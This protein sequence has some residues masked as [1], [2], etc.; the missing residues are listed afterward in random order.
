MGKSV[1]RSCLD[2]AIEQSGEALL[3]GILFE[4]DPAVIRMWLKELRLWRERFDGSG[5]IFMKG[6][7]M[8][9]G[10]VKWFSDK[11][12]YG[13]IK[14]EEDSDLFVHHTGIDAEGFRS[15]SEGQ[16]VSFDIAQGEKGPLATGVKVIEEA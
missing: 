2:K 13:F 9:T 1:S 7:E 4:E 16:K 12:G 14:R 3:S 15:L 6:T 11:K 5:S 10:V 8:A